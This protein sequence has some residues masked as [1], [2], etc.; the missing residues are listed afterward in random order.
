VKK[1]KMLHDSDDEIHQLLWKGEKW[2][3]LS[4][5]KKCRLTHSFGEEP[6]LKLS[7]H[8]QYLI[9]GTRLH[10]QPQ[11]CRMNVYTVPHEKLWTKIFRALQTKT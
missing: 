2:H 5:V 6:M 11:A 10:H 7:Q 1:R 4:N 9:D 3:D 8:L